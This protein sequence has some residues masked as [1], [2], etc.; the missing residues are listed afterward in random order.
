MKWS[1]KWWTNKYKPNILLSQDLSLLNLRIYIW[2]CVLCY[3]VFTVQYC[4]AQIWYNGSDFV[5]IIIY[6]FLVFGFQTICCTR[7]YY[8]YGGR[9][10]KGPKGAFKAQLWASGLNPPYWYSISWNQYFLISEFVLGFPLLVLNIMK[11]L[12]TNARICTQF[13]IGTQLCIY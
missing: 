1:K 3:T 7:F 9:V 5:R 13:S 6:E 10:P 11:I 4:S 8:W 2:E 12:C